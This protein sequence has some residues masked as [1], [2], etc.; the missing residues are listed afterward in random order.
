MNIIEYIYIHMYIEIDAVRCTIHTKVL[1]HV[2]LSE[3]GVVP[4]VPPMV[5]HHFLFPSM[6]ISWVEAIFRHDT[7][8]PHDIVGYMMLYII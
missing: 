3:N 6:A 4:K 1:A 5:Y 7:T 8:H 2:S